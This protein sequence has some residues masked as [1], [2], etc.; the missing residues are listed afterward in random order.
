MTRNRVRTWRTMAQMATFMLLFLK[1]FFATRK[2]VRTWKTMGAAANSRNSAKTRQ[3]IV[4]K[5]NRLYTLNVFSRPTISSSFFGERKGWEGKKRTWVWVNEYR[6]RNNW[7][8]INFR[9]K[10][11]I[12]EI[13]R[14][15]L[16]NHLDLKEMKFALCLIW[17]LS[18]IS[19]SPIK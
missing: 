1:E 11:E 4:I 14:I 12:S 15:G 3:I 10:D 16:R 9:F 8:Q 18:Y 13:E 7:N 5:A 19:L 2:K 6:S 17:H